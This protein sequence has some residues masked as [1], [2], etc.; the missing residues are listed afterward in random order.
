MADGAERVASAGQYGGSAGADGIAGED[1]RRRVQGGG[2]LGRAVRARAAVTVNASGSID[3]GASSITIPAGATESSALTVSRADG[4]SGAV[5]VDLGDLPTL[6]SD[7]SGYSLT[8][9]AD[10]PLR[11]M[12]ALPTDATLSACR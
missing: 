2:P 4:Q 8:K 3:G 9:D 5:T 12:E 7:H 6:P 11:L 1:R 10:L